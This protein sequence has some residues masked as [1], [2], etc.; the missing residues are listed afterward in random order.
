MQLESEKLGKV[1]YSEE[2][3]FKIPSGLL[4]F[5]EDKDYI[6]HRS[7][8]VHP[9]I[10]LQSLD[11]QKLSFLLIDPLITHP[12]YRLNLKKEDVGDLNI[13]DSDQTKVYVIVSIPE[14]PSKMTANFQGP[15]VFN[16]TK[17][18]IQQVVV[19]SESLKVPLVK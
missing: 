4:G 3:I 18:I 7:D 19:E 5:P 11:T 8:N 14:D 16:E 15:L 12:D 6:L 2:D 10:W 9:F 17:K 13:D 1:D